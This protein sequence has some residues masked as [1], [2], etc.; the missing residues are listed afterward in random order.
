MAK[1]GQWIENPITGQ[2]IRFLACA[3]ENGGA[4]WEVEW[5]VQP[6]QGK[7]PSAHFHPLFAERFGIL[8]GAARYR[9]GGQEEAAQPG[10]VVHIAAGSPHLHP[11][12]V[13]DDELHMRH[14]I[15]LT[16]PNLPL[17]N[18]A[19]AF[20]ESLFALAR[21]QGGQGWPAQSLAIRRLS[22]SRQPAGLSGW[23]A[24]AGSRHFFGGLARLG[25]WLGYRAR[26]P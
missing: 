6:R 8:A 15:E 1:P 10:D 13:S 23:S 18:A 12:S 2:R 17:L 3:E 20:F 22:A 21:R 7:F 4:R 26:Y 24:H 5:F 16:Q 11:W 14:V 25:R 19:E 9:L